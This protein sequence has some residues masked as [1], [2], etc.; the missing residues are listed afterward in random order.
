MNAKANACQQNTVRLGEIG[1]VKGDK[2]VDKIYKILTCS[3]EL[4]APV[5]VLQN[6][7]MTLL[8]QVL[9]KLFTNFSNLSFEIL[10]IY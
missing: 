1:H 9:L 2:N 5:I 7:M 6:L 4:E 10:D 3:T 8:M